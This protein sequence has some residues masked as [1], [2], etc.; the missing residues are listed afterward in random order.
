MDT[1]D[2]GSK[3]KL[4][5]HSNFSPCVR[6]CKVDNSNT[7]CVSCFR[8]LTEISTWQWMTEEEKAFTVAL[9]ELRKTVHLLDKENEQIKVDSK[10]RRVK[11]C[12]GHDTQG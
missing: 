3:Q 2:L 11:P 6:M 7:Y 9:T 12:S 10:D 4:S 1:L 8:T 5:T